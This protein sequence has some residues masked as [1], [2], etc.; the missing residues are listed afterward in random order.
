VCEAEAS[1]V[2]VSEAAARQFNR[3]QKFM[4]GD[5]MVVA[6][7]LV[8]G[9]SFVG[10]IHYFWLRDAFREETP[11]LDGHDERKRD[12]ELSSIPNESS[13]NTDSSGS[14]EMT[15]NASSEGARLTRQ[16]SRGHI[17]GTL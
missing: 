8:I 4:I 14:E 2:K 7:V 5:Y 13:S 17:Y 15:A 11:A 6:L 1:G 16:A 3:K 12:H 9:L 10:A